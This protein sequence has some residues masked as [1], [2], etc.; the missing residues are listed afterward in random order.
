MRFSVSAVH[1]I[2]TP[3]TKVE[4]DY[5]KFETA[6]VRSTKMDTELHR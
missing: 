5:M 2:K 6:L 1:L 3:D 4:K